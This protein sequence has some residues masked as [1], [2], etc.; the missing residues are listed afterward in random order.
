MQHIRKYF[1]VK[2]SKFSGYFGIPWKYYVVTE[3]QH[4]EWEVVTKLEDSL[5]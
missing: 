4:W 2:N 5:K 1:M 3:E